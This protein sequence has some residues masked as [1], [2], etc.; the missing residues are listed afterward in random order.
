M[1]KTEIYV[2]SNSS[3]FR[4]SDWLNH[5]SK[6][7]THSFQELSMRFYDIFLAGNSLGSQP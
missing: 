2:V 5:T 7:L 1:F 3:Q 4:K 6:R